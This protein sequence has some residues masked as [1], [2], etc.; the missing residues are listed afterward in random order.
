MKRRMLALLLAMML[1]LTACGRD[2]GDRE[3]AGR[4]EPQAETQAPEENLSLGRLEGGVY[5]NEYAG[6]G[7]NLDSSWTIYSA[8]ELQQMPSAALEA[9]EG[10]ELAE[11]IDVMDQFTDIMAE[12]VD[13]LLTFN[14]LYQKLSLEERLGNAM[15]S[16]ADLIEG[17]LGMQNQMIEA[18]AQAG[19]MVESMEAVK[20]TFLGE[21]RTAL[22]TVST[23]EGTPYIILQ[24]YNHQLGSYSV[25]L[26]LGSYLED[27][28]MAMLDLFYEVN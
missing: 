4:V 21:T 11:A 5:T 23:V 17:I 3:V 26:T 15:V 16:E 19:I 10:S 14:V 24:I 25:T 2:G 22:R 12:N 9:M 6:F 27:N 8:E 1:L 28:T 20:V 13:Q 7:C 18:Y